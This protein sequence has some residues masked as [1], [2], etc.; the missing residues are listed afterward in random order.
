MTPKQKQRLF[1]FF[2][3]A[4]L[5]VPI[6]FVIIDSGEEGYGLAG[7]GIMIMM[8]FLGI[9]S[10]ILFAI[11]HIAGKQKS[12][13]AQLNND[14]KHRIKSSLLYLVLGLILIYLPHL[15][16]IQGN[17]I[18]I[19]IGLITIP[20]GIVLLIMSLFEGIAVLFRK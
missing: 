6:I 8:G 14:G 7:V 13:V 15:S 18:S 5:I 16:F 9:A 20:I 1:N 3:L 12:D 19:I 4:L 2:A 10:V 17:T 11:A